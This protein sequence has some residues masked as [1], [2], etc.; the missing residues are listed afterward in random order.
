MPRRT[1]LEVA[2]AQTTEKQ[3]KYEKRLRGSGLTKCCV[4]VPTAE[5]AA[6]KE[7]AATARAAHPAKLASESPE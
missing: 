5:V 7:A 4:W 3:A 2:I 6:F 1:P